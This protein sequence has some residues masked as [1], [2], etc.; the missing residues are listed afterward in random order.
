MKQKAASGVSIDPSAIPRE[1]LKPGFSA[2]VLDDFSHAYAT[3]FMIALILVAVVIIPASFL[4]K[5]PAIH[6]QG[7]QGD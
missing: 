1:S 6:T 2:D 3:V 4:P 7:V 5:K